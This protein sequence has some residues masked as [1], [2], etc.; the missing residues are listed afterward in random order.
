MMLLMGARPVRAPRKWGRR[1]KRRRSDG[2]ESLSR[3]RVKWIYSTMVI[4]GGSMDKGSQEQQISQKLLS[5]HAPGMQREEAS[6][7]ANQGRGHGG[8]HLRRDSHPSDPKIDRE[9]RTHLEP[10]ADLPSL[11]TFFQ[12]PAQS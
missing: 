1:R 10:D 7:E 12:G 4:D 3:P 9:L 5:L 2:R 6:S 11:L 8:D